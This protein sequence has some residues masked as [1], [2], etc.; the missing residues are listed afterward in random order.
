MMV[1]SLQIKLRITA[2][3]LLLIAA[4]NVLAVGFSF[5][6]E[7]S[8]KGLGMTTDYLKQSPFTNFFIPGL[9]LFIANGVLSIFMAIISIKKGKHYP[10]LISFQGCIPLG[11]IIIQLLMLQFLNSCPW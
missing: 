9:I 8:G 11:W 10:L 5:I 3:V 2:I 1:Q 6:V 7:P 4:T